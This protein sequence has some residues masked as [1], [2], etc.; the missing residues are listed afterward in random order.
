[1]IADARAFC[2][3]GPLRKQAGLGYAKPQ[4]QNSRVFLVL[5]LQKKNCFPCLKP[6]P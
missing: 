1:L 4:P 3:S 2:G 6:Q 5:F